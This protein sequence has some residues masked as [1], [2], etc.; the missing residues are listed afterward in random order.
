MRRQ[1]RSRWGRLR[2]R[3]PDSSAERTDAHH[4]AADAGIAEAGRQPVEEAGGRS[5]GRGGGARRAVQSE[6][7][8]VHRAETRQTAEG[9]LRQDGR[10]GRRGVEGHQWI[11]GVSVFTRESR[12]SEFRLRSRRHP[13][14]R[15]GR[16]LGL[17]AGS[18]D[19]Q[20]RHRLPRQPQDQRQPRFHLPGR[21]VHCVHRGARSERNIDVEFQRREV[22]TRV[23]RCFRRL[24]GQGLGQHQ[25]GHGLRPVPPVDPAPQS[26]CRNAG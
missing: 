10:L 15:A 14:E 16:P 20:I 23:R 12:R 24:Q 3:C 25:S 4:A 1:C 7:S 9:L 21:I 19:E 6:G 2:R 22:L 26:F 17:S 13:E 18:V 11:G 8:A 5:A